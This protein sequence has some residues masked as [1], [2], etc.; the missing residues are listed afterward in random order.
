MVSLSRIVR[1]YG[2]AGGVNS[3]LA[4]W[5]FVDETMFLTKA[6]HVG[7]VYGSAC[8][9]CPRERWNIDT[10]DG[11]DNGH[12]GFHN[13]LFGRLQPPRAQHGNEC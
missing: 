6:G 11:A 10:L 3:L 12:V 4:L 13:P 7:L 1:D 5:G 8:A 2:E 9:A